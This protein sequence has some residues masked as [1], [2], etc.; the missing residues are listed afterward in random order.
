M[1]DLNPHADKHNVPGHFS[2]AGVG[3]GHNPGRNC[4]AIIGCGAGI[5]M[6]DETLVPAIAPPLAPV[7]VTTA[8]TPAAAVIS[9]EVSPAPSVAPAPPMSSESTISIV[10]VLATIYIRMSTLLPLT[11]EEVENDRAQGRLRH[12]SKIMYYMQ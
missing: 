10:P 5:L 7:V 4:V 3:G 11:P 12:H 2:A 1:R 6:P 8:P 9:A